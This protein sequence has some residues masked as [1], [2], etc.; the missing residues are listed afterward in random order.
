MTQPPTPT[1]PAASA[2]KVSPHT[3]PPLTPAHLQNCY[4][5]HTAIFLYHFSH[6]L[7]FPTPRQELSLQK[8]RGP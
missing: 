4:E 2:V 3:S 6:R 1:I 7:Y 5:Q 8:M